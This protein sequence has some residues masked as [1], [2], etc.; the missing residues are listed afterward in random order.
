MFCIALFVLYNVLGDSVDTP[1]VGGLKFEHLHGICIGNS[2]FLVLIDRISTLY[3]T[4]PAG[5]LHYQAYIEP[6]CSTVTS[7]PVKFSERSTWSCWRR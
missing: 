3:T 5:I 4:G 1:R 6:Q 2:E 7:K